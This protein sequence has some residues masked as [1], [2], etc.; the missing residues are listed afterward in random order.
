MEVEDAARVLGAA[1]RFQIL[2][3]MGVYT[4]DRGEAVRA[5]HASQIKQ[6]K[7]RTSGADMRHKAAGPCN[8]WHRAGDETLRGQRR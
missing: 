5:N 2:E 7:R 1:T 6:S 3:S 4:L 8:A